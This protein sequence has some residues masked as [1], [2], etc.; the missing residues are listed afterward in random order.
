MNDVAE[1]LAAE[2]IVRTSLTDDEEKTIN[3]ISK[4]IRTAL[5]KVSENPDHS[6]SAMN[7]D[8]KYMNNLFQK[9]K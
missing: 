3:C 6:V 1:L 4:A 9:L 2:S 7:R 8:A 5:V